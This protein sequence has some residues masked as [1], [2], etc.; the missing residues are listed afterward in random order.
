MSEIVSQC[1]GL[2]WDQHNAAKS[3]PEAP[4]HFGPANDGIKEAYR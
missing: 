3:W 4:A 1:T 2:Q